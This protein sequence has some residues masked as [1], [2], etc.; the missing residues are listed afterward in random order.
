[1]KNEL[2]KTV[3]MVEHLPPF[4]MLIEKGTVCAWQIRQYKVHKETACFIWLIENFDKMLP[5]RTRVVKHSKDDIIIFSTEEGA[6]EHI[7]R[8]IT[9]RILNAESSLRD[10][11]LEMEL[12]EKGLYQ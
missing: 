5:E 8:C 2:D 11:K 4:I 9:Y 6:R 3:Y 12:F 7:L 10:A 1:M